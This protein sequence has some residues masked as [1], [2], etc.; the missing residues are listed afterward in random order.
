MSVFSNPAGEA[1]NATAQYVKAL[2]DVAGDGD[3]LPRMT[4]AP[5]RVAEA[6]RGL[7]ATQLQTPEREGKWC[8]AE[9]LGHLADTDL[10]AGFRFRMAL[11]HDTPDIPGYDQD[12]WCKRLQYKDIPA[13]DSLAQLRILRDANMKM[14]ARLPIESRQRVGIHSE[15]GH[16]TVEHMIRLIA[17]HDVVH[18]R[19]I[20]RIR[21]VVT[22]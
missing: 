7:S 18:L 15:R 16:E 10:V 13:E 12:L 2:L 3:P 6:I 1:A 5:D 22:S 4:T 17:G 19:Q 8:I 20:E 21:S 11:A 9:V 14:F